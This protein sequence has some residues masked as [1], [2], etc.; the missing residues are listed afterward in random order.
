MPLDAILAIL[1]LVLA[2]FF[3]VYVVLPVSFTVLGVLL[4]LSLLTALGASLVF[5]S[6]TML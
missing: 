2:G 3:I 6:H 4:L 1:A 5:N